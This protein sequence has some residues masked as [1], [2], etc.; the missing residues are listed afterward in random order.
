QYAGVPAAQCHLHGNAKTVQELEAAVEAGI[1]RIIVDNADELATLIAICTRLQKQQKIMLRIA[2]GVA[3]GGNA[4]IQTGKKTSKFGFNIGD[5]SA[6][7]AIETAFA[8]PQLELLGLHAHT[9][10]QI[11]SFAPLQATLRNLFAVA[12]EAQTRIGWQMREISP[13]GGL[14][15]PINGTQKAFPIADYCAAIV[16]T[17]QVE[18]ARHGLPLPHLCIEPGRAVVARS[19]V[20]VYTVT[21]H[22]PQDEHPDFLHVDGGVGDNLRPAMY[23]ANYAALSVLRPNQPHTT[24]YQLAGRYCES[25]DILIP[26]IDL[27]P[28]Q[29]GDLIALPAAGAYT[30]SM[31][32]NYNGIGRPPLLLLHAGQAR[33]IQ[34]R[35]TWQDIISRDQSL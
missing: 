24:P 23:G 34:R 6:M 32:S 29:Q 4:K 8:S 18:A 15:V 9:G 16:E 10:S 14:A 25:G 26:K 2:P 11:R 28:S 1:G 27:P 33:I 13:G 12:G 19:V 17:A 3:A 22:K 5:G 20:A 30:L 7:R 31:A 21:G 35:E